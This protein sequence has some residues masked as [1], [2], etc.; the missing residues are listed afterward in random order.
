MDYQV[1][2][3]KHR[4]TS[5]DKVFDKDMRSLHLCKQDVKKQDTTRQ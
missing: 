5:R 4:D 1:K 2:I 3:V